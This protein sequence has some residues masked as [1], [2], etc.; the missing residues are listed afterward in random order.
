VQRIWIFVTL[1]LLVWLS[2]NAVGQRQGVTTLSV[3]VAPES[4]VDPSR[5]PV[6][7]VITGDGR[8]DVASQT[9]LVTALVRSLPGRQ[10]H[11]TA[12]L[13][14]LTGPT[15]AI[16]AAQFEWSG[17]V[18]HA[19]GRARSASCTSGNFANG[20]S[21]DLVSG[22][23]E[24]GSLTCSVSF[25]LANQRSLSPGTYTAVFALTLQMR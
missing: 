24:S 23:F 22:W 12:D 2:G 4:R 3:N 16:A 20:A 10:V 15:G 7:F 6:N 1:T 25:R 14:S 5:V 21:P 11:L 17:S 8:D 9:T 18:V 13:S 19:T